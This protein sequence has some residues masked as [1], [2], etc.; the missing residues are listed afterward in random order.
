MMRQRIRGWPRWQGLGSAT[1]NARAQST[2]EYTALSV[3]VLAA[4]ISMQIYV[5]RGFSGRLKEASDTVGE[6]YEP[7]ATTGRSTMGSTSQS[8]TIAV[9]VN[10]V[11]LEAAQKLGCLDVNGDG[12]CDAQDQ[13]AGGYLTIGSDDPAAAS[14][15][16]KK[17]DIDCDGTCD[18]GGI[19]VTVTAS[20]VDQEKTTRDVDETVGAMGNKLW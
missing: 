3:I 16:P 10:E 18:N 6:Q 14:H 20:C 7:R 15:C 2:F 17:C 19:F 11:Q 1:N 5:K 12:A 4:L 13:C 8:R 9:T